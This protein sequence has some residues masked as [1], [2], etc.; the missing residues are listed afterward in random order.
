M[1]T[2]IYQLKRTFGTPAKVRLVGRSVNRETGA[3][4]E[5][6]EDR[7]IQRLI[8]LPP[9]LRWTSGPLTQVT[10]VNAAY[11]QGDQEFLLDVRDFPSVY[12]MKHVIVVNDVVFH[13]VSFTVYPDCIYIIGRN[14]HTP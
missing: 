7:E 1:R 3:V 12:S 13:T 6:V 9:Q 10:R 11:Q 4:T 2:A 8:K 14:E 5:V